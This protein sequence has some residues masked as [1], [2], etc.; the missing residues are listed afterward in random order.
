[1]H[2]ST[3]PSSAH[4]FPPRTPPLTLK[5]LLP[6]ADP[7]PGG[8]GLSSGHQRDVQFTSMLRAFRE[9]G[10]LMRGDEAAALLKQRNAGD[11]SSLARWIVT[12][13]VLSFDWRGELWVPLFQFDLADMSIRPGISRI[14]AELMPAFDGWALANWF[15]TPNTRL[16]ERLPADLLATEADAV[17][18]AARADRFAVMG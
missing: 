11:V 15:A 7:A 6:A 14:A 18:Q 13:Q 16:Q 10:G 2:P 12:E 1:M 3:A 9:T 5:R 4:A 17:M 8:G